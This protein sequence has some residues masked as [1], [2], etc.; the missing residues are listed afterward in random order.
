MSEKDELREILFA[1]SEKTMQDKIENLLLYTQKKV[2]EREIEL[3]K[4]FIRKIA[5]IN[6]ESA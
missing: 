2:L 4:E 5:K 1:I 3:G 6:Q